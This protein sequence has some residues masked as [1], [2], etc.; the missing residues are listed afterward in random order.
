M[1]DQSVLENHHVA[2]T[3]AVMNRTDSMHT[4]GESSLNPKKIGGSCDIMENMSRVDYKRARNMMIYCILATDMSK[5]FSELG[6]FKARIGSADF[7]PKTS[8]KELLVTEMFH[9]A[10]ISNSTKV[11]ELS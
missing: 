8:D 6:K 7:D 3:F 1:L 9:L 2:Q 10:D 4:A 11:W 5:H